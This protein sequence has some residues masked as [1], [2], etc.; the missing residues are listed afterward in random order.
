[1]EESNINSVRAGGIIG[2]HEV[3]L[4]FPFQTVRIKHE[5][6]AREAFGNGA[7]FALKE[8]Q[9]RSPGFYNMEDLVGKSFFDSIW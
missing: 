3:L 2:V 6:I 9:N 5:S 8:L 1:M 7:R 4:G